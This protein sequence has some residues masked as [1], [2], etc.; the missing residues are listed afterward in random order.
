MPDLL[1]D[2]T[3][4]TALREWRVVVV[5]HGVL[6][7]GSGVVVDWNGGTIEADEELAIID[8]LRVYARIFQKEGMPTLT[9]DSTFV[10][11]GPLP[12][13]GLSPD[14]SSA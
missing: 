3:F 2:W 8:I 9:T 1:R 4:S 14:P 12:L 5:P 13:A 10:P 7:D 6:I 11:H